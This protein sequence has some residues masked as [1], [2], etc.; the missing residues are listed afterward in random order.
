VPRWRHD[1]TLSF[2][3]RVLGNLSDMDPHGRF[4]AP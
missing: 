3:S 1:E 4:Y 2:I